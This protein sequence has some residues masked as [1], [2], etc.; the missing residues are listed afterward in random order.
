VIY[1]ADAKSLVRTLWHNRGEPT[2]MGC[3][4]C[5][6]RPECGGLQVSASVFSCLDH[7]NCADRQSCQK[8]CPNNR[9]FVAR[10][11]EVRG[12]GFDDIE[13]RR[14]IPLVKLPLFAH[15]LF[16]YPKVA[17]PVQLPVAAIPL[18]A[19]FNRS[20]KGGVALTRDQVEER[21]RLAAKTPLILSG[22]EL[23][24]KIEKFWGVE[25]GR[26]ELLAGIRALDP[27]IVTT[28]NYS[29][30]IDA[31]RHDAMHSLKR[32]L[33]AWS[34][35]HDA[36]LRSALHLN[37]VTDRDYSRMAEFLSV[38][39]EIRAVSVEFDTGAAPEEQG[40]YHAK[41]LDGLVQR[42]G[43]PLHLVFRGAARW[44]PELQKSFPSIT[45]LNGSASV[46][47]R[48]RRR[49]VFADEQL[50]W[51]S[52]PTQQGAPL[53]E[54]LAHNLRNVSMWFAAKTTAPAPA[55]KKVLLE[56]RPKRHDEAGQL[57]LL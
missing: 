14:A 15:L 49:A 43:R 52:A 19:V 25:R 21:F 36:G 22:V 24:R 17:N 34:E 35:L 40:H 4:D 11:H 8:V 16:T 6:D 51:E 54:L 7:C 10:I 12:F 1:K 33:L 55:R 3:R 5:P 2:A 57:G 26:A 48:K 53:D 30:F 50:R 46:R 39:S 31:P 45:A 27:L 29:V 9:N 32:I 56:V 44:V 42:I 23:D 41:Q 18:S 38:H 28:P 47:T 37:A 13:R 20:G